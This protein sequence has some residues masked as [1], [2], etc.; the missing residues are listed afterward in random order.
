MKCCVWL[1]APL[2]GRTDLGY[3]RASTSNWLAVSPLPTPTPAPHPQASDATSLPR[4]EAGLW[5]CH[6]GST[7]L[8]SQADG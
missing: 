6:H 8:E 3:R 5:D 2:V 4:E 1:V 7:L